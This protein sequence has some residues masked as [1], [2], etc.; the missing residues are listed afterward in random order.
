MVVWVSPDG[1]TWDRLT[2]D[3]AFSGS[4][5]EVAAAASGPNGIVIVGS[6]GDSPVGSAGAIWHSSDGRQWH[7]VPANPEIFGGDGYQWVSDVIA[8]QD[9]FIAVGGND[10]SAIVWTSQDGLSWQAN[11]D[12][13]PGSIRGVE[14]ADGVLFAVG[15]LV[16]GGLIRATMWSS[17]DG[18]EWQ[19]I[20]LDDQQAFEIH[21]NTVLYDIAVSGDQ[22]VAVGFG[23]IWRGLIDR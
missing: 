9:R 21:E 4:A 5:V 1:R 8:Y 3:S 12:L 19:R 6:R 22:V 23:G 18:T 2:D 20:P 13:G 11:R 7:Q 10:G 16:V 15:D 17:V 14:A